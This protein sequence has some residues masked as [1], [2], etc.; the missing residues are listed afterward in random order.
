MQFSELVIIL[1]VT[2]VS[3]GLYRN[4]GHDH[5]V[6]LIIIIMAMST[7]SQSRKYT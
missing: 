2:K 1:T 5:R 4:F 6:M 3:E 7:T